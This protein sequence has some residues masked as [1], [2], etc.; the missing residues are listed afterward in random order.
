MTLKPLAL[1]LAAAG[2]AAAL[3]M[4]ARGAGPAEG[5]AS[6]PVQPVAA[7]IAADSY[8]FYMPMQGLKRPAH[9]F[10]VKCEASR[11]AGR[12][13]YAGASPQSIGGRV[14]GGYEI[15]YEA[16]DAAGKPCVFPFSPSMPQVIGSLNNTQYILR[17]SVPGRQVTFRTRDE[18]GSI[19]VR[20]LDFGRQRV[21][22]E[23][24]DIAV[25]FP[26]AVQAKGAVHLETFGGQAP[27]LFSAVIRRCKVFGGKNGL[28]VPGGQTMLYVE[29]SEFNGNI[30]GNVD[31]E[32]TTYINGILVSHLRNSV[33][34]GQHAWADQASGHQL[35]D[36]AYLRVYENVTV[37][38]TPNG[39]P[40][41]AMPPVDISAMGFTWSNNLRIVRL[42]PQQAVRESL[43][44]LR[45]EIIYG[46]PGMYPWNPL[47]DARWRMPAQPLSVLDQ[48]YLSVF[49]NTRIESFRTEP[50][51]FAPRPQGTHVDGTIPPNI[52]GNEST[53]PAQ[54]RQVSLAF[55]T[56]GRFTRTYG[57]PGW[58]FVNPALPAAAM[59]VSDRDAFIRHA[60]KLIGR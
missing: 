39:G 11:R 6:S 48:V 57:K 15:V 29:D 50:F 34:R 38:N 18:W 31:Q 27:G 14:E 46:A 35:K 55:N 56:M 22:F 7:P 36:K 52:R 43:V 51:V 20:L 53:S 45:S 33:W 17:S 44:D 58:T 21:H 8:P 59:W 5:P 49:F 10:L 23:M 2:G 13:V 40:P 12:E 47:V 24:R 42:A 19:G 32:H 16:N 60:L 54:Q 28:F 41:S 3:A 26:A 30:G 37:S 1:I 4:A 9:K 25:D